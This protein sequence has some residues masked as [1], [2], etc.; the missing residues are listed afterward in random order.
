MSHGNG[1]ECGELG[2]VGVGIRAFTAFSFFIF[3]SLYLSALAVLYKMDGSLLNLSSSWHF[4]FVEFPLYHL[5]RIV[6]STPQDWP[7][8][9]STCLSWSGS[10]L[11][12]LT[13]FPLRT[14]STLFLGLRKTLTVFCPYFL[15]A[16]VPLET[17]KLFKAETFLSY[18]FNLKD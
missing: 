2:I 18:F 7:Q 11:D 3:T 5:P 9:T 1:L 10:I 13:L 14:L 12:L 15:C 16:Y 6:P 4:C 8:Y 17:T